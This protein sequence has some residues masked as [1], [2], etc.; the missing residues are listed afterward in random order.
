MADESR[1]TYEPDSQLYADIADAIESGKSYGAPYLVEVLQRARNVL[2]HQGG[3]PLPIRPDLDGQAADCEAMLAA[4]SSV[5][6]APRDMR[7]RRMEAAQ[8]ALYDRIERRV[9]GLL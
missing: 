4:Y 7:I 5:A 3:S 8:F 6:K 2:E 9:T 1:E